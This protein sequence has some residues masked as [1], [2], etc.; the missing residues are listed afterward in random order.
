[1][2]GS[3]CSP[4][5]GRNSAA[6]LLSTSAT[7]RCPSPSSLHAARS[8]CWIFCSTLI[9]CPPLLTGPIK[10]GPHPSTSTYVIRPAGKSVSGSG[11]DKSGV[12]NP[13]PF[14]ITVQG[15]YPGP[16]TIMP[17][18]APVCSPPR[19]TATPFTKT[20]RIPSETWCGSSYVARS[21]TVSGS[22]MT[23]SA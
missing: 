2:D 20:S 12:R 16:R 17:G 18:L 23:M 21:M 14:P 22:K 1:M 3:V 4:P 7:C 15:R 11:H 10:L 13:L 6:I 5:A 8:S 19:T 9:V